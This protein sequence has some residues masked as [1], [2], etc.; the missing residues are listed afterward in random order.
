MA[1][2]I[3]NRA[4]LRY[5]YGAVTETVASNLASTVLNDPLT[6]TKS[7]LE[8]AYRG[9][10]PITYVIT[11][12]NGSSTALSN[13]TIE[14]DLG[15]YAPQT[16]AQATPLTYIG[17][18]QLYLDGV[19]SAELTPA[20]TEG[21][22]TFTIPAIAPGSN[23]TI[24]YKAEPNEYAPMLAGSKITNTASFTPAVGAEPIAASHT[25]PAEAYAAVTI[26]KEM[27]PNPVAD[28]AAL[29]NTFTVTNTG[30]T[31]AVD[32][33][34]TDAFMTPLNDLA[35]TVDGVAVP[36]TDFTFENNVLTL[37]AEG[38]A[39][40]LTVPAATYTQDPA[41]GAVSFVPGVTTVVVTGTI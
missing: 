29:V 23:A 38:A 15:T 9:G 2:T 4:N 28:G 26:E 39:T 30:N 6:V 19:F 12:T 21:S 33:V 24:L 25:I 8:T 27:S 22:V 17:P 20:I 40:A 16:G 31:E 14:D 5:T 13:V 1:T 36:E 32:L 3:T 41:T 35:V 11:V 7:S 18:A 37:P 34:L 10:E